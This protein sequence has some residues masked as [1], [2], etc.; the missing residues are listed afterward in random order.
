[1]NAS[2]TSVNRVVLGIVAVAFVASM[3]LI[4]ATSTSARVDRLAGN[5]STE[6]L[7]SVPV[8]E[9]SGARLV[10]MRFTLEPGTTIRAHS[11]SGPAVF[12]VISGA[13]TT[14]LVRGAAIVNRDEVEESAEIGAMTYLYDGE[15][16]AFAPNAG[17]TIEN[18]SSEPLL[19]V[20]SLLLKPNEPIFDYDYWP[21]PHTTAR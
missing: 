13:L 8:A 2:R 18:H 11:H 10:L 7:A 1:M 5:M 16:I 19:L 15:S 20:A 12:T 3:S 9:S 17:V 4:P 21:P 14:E 6:T